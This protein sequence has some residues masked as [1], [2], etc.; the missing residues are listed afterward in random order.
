MSKIL[1]I[2][3]LFPPE[4]VVSASLSFD[5]AVNLSENNK[6]TVICPRPTRPNGYKFKK[7][8]SN[9]KY[10]LIQL[11]SFT[12]PNSKIIGRFRES[13]SFGKHCK[14]Y[15]IKNFD[16]IDCIYLNAWPLFAQFLI[17]K[18]A[19]RFNIPCVTHIQDIYPES[20]TN[21]LPKF[22]SI[23]F[24]NIFSPLDRYILNNSKKIIGISQSMII[25]LSKNRN[26]HLDKFELVRNWQEDDFFLDCNT[27]TTKTNDFVYMY[28][29]SI[30][31]SAGVETLIYSFNKANLSN[32][33]LIIAGSGSEKDKCKNIAQM[34]S[35]PN[36]SFCDVSPSDVPELQS[37]SDVLLL[38]L[39]KGI[40]KTATPS[41]LTA[42]LLSGRPVIA[43]VEEQTDV[44]NIIMTVGCGLVA[45][46]ENIDLIALSLEN[47]YKMD[48]DVLKKMGAKG[49]K[50]AELNLL[51]KVNLNK[52]LLIIENSING[53]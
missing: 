9:S 10:N 15:I 16:Q 52:L 31:K 22:I 18:T 17:I 21:K 34:L 41:K 32:S 51:K 20:F 44:A 23:F 12:C 50:F 7:R 28:L 53:N 30:S 13:Y 35:N 5:L 6:V 37:K 33:K 43:C 8:V 25:Y 24:L 3:A 27:T 36:I 2:S 1:I 46:P 45:E 26:I 14:N 47:I 40:A 49:K 11:D 48:R 19:K 42:Y 39:K 29:G 4:P 38:P